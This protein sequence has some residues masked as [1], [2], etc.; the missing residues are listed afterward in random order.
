MRWLKL[1]TRGAG[2]IHFRLR[3]Y[4]LHRNRYGDTWCVVDLILQD[5]NYSL[6]DDEALEIPEVIRLEKLI[7]AALAGEVEDRAFVGTTEPYMEFDF[8][9]YWDD[10]Q[11]KQIFYM[12]WEVMLW[13]GWPNTTHEIGDESGSRIIIGLYE[14]EMRLL[15]TYLKFA[16][17][18]IKEDEPEIVRLIESGILYNEE[19]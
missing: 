10:V 7:D 4:D 13:N 12:E 11:R 3:G 8:Q 2:E 9:S 17:K 18:E 16:R 1:K 14:D 19:P 5:L 6:R 15:S